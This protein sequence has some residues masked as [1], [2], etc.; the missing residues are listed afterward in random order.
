MTNWPALADV[1]RNVSYL[2]DVEQVR[3]QFDAFLLQSDPADAFAIAGI[4]SLAHPFYVPKMN[5]EVASSLAIT[6]PEFGEAIMRAR[7][8]ASRARQPNVLVACFPKSASTFITNC[9]LSVLDVRGASLMASS[10]STQAPYSMGITLREQETDELALLKHG[11][12]GGGYVAQ[13][14]VRCTPY[15]CQQLELY[16][17]R[18]II[19][20]RNIEDSL[21]SLDDMYCRARE[22]DESWRDTYAMYFSDAMPHNYRQLDAE[23]RFMLLVDRQLAWY[24]QFYM[25]WKRCEEMGLVKPCWVSYER[26]F[27]GDKRVLAERIA[28]FIGPDFVD[29]EKLTDKLSERKAVG[30]SRFNK[31]VS[32]RG[33]G[34]PESVKRRIR[35][36]LEPYRAECDLSEILDG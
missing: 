17:I 36:S 12:N 19:T 6:M 34:I 13:H 30:E 18:P 11:S 31:G 7:L 10:F 20:Y 27:L 14:H 35:Q 24:V 21:V 5:D 3:E 9:L 4:F 28:N 32:G 1:I 26:D 25:S 33:K 22:T 29:M 8:A 2:T 23:T 16:N 15:L